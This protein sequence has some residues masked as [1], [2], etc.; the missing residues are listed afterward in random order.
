MVAGSLDIPGMFA[1]LYGAADTLAN[2]ADAV[3]RRD[4]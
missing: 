1:P 3:A 2:V 4:F